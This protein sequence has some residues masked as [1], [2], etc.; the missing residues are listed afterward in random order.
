M[1]P[2]T[3]RLRINSEDLQVDNNNWPHAAVAGGSDAPVGQ[4]SLDGRRRN[5][6]QSADGGASGGSK[7]VLSC[8]IDHE[9][10]D[11]IVACTSDVSVL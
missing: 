4:L 1:R 10:D 7:S 5:V 9:M 6:T 3:P 2:S 8:I 11:A